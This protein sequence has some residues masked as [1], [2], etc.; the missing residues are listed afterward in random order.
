MFFRG[1]LIAIFSSFSI[2]CNAESELEK[3][4]RDHLESV[5]SASIVLTDSDVI[6][7]GFI[8]FDPKEWIPI[9]DRQAG[10]ESLVKR[11]RLKTFSAPVYSTPIFSGSRDHVYFDSRVSYLEINESVQLQTFSANDQEQLQEQVFDGYIGTV[12]QRRLFNP[13]LLEAGVGAHLMHYRNHYQY[14]DGGLASA[15]DIFDKVVLNTRMN[16]IIAEP[17]AR[18]VYENALGR[19]PFQFSSTLNYAYG[20]TLDSS[21]SVVKAYPES[22]RWTNSAVLGRTMRQVFGYS[23]HLKFLLKRVDVGG[24]AVSSM[25][26]HNYYEF[27]FGWLLY[28]GGQD[29]WIRNIGI[30]LSVNVGSDL[31]G[32]SFVLLFNE[33]Y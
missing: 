33:D 7:L 25:G 21:S 17:F 14:A 13:W 12:W 19:M 11:G 20:Q 18:A 26:T 22:W 28:V 4:A 30:G 8:D 15:K 29:A 6:T 31:S 9:G 10:G 16:A 2:L 1:G 32:G 27:G 3:I 23:N 5:L 24:E